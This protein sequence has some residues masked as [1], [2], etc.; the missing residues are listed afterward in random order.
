MK[1]ENLWIHLALAPLCIALYG[2]NSDSST[3]GIPQL[4]AAIPASITSCATLATEFNYADTT[5]ISAELIPA[6]DVEY[7]A[8]EIYP[9]PSHCL[10]TGKMNE[11]TGIGMDGDAEY[12]IGF[13]MRLPSDWNGR[14]YYQ[15]NGGLDGKV[16]KAVGRFLTS[17]SK[18]SGALNKG[19]AVISSD[20][21]H[22]SATPM[23]GLDPQARLDYGYNAVAE[24]TPMAKS[25]IETAYGKQPDR[26]YFGGCSNGGRHTMVAATRYADLYD[27]FLVGNPGFNLPKAAVSQLYGIQQYSSLVDI[28]VENVL[29]SLQNGFTQ[30][31]FA[32]V[33]SKVAQQCD[34][35]D[36]ASDGMVQ[37]TYGCQDAFDLDRDVPT[38]SAD[39]D[40]TCLTA[41][42]K[43]V[44][45]NIMSGPRNSNTDAAIYS[46]FPYDAGM[47]TNDYYN[48]EF[49]MAMMRDPGAVAFIF[50][51]APT[52]YNGSTELGAYEFVMP[53]DMDTDVER[54]Y[55]IDDT[56]T[57]S[58][59]TFMTPPNP[60]DLTVLRDRGAKIMVVH[61]TSDAVFSP[62]DTVNWYKGLQNVNENQA[63]EF[64]RLYL[65]PGMN[66]C[67]KGLA[68]DRFDML[69][70]LVAWVEQGQAP[71]SINAS[72][73]SENTELPAN[74]SK[75]RT[76]PLCPFPQVATYSGTGNMEDAV[77][78]ICVT[79][80]Q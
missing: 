11:R 27:G 67:G 36:G 69:D 20:T 48:W 1:T 71:E 79:P 15:A 78:F 14:F 57:Q 19:F 53:F 40:G 3:E 9:S 75:T 16:Q 29:A 60:T 54:I 25:L 44:M 13:E 10:I 72:V 38:C 58:G 12:A 64:A 74:W 42:Q 24:L 32:L 59:M 41:A 8:G 55:A 33:S 26:S 63:D 39:R 73:R 2:C 34:A 65:V 5:I 17:A 66:H 46:D 31:E 21:G 28:D 49:F 37:D 50:S 35:L 45:T 70:S 61:G 80:E 4:E 68:T 18:D 30:E 22:A 52:P 51:T 43:S 47:G 56:Y 7:D 23:F 62:N 6:G 77:N 76:R